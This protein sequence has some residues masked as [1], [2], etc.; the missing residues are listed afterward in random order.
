MS[1][2]RK[3]LK[4]KIASLSALGAGALIAGAG[5]AD[6]STIYSGP[7]NVDVG[8]SGQPFYTLSLSGSKTFLSFTYFARTTTIA[9]T[10]RLHYRSISGFGPAAAGVQIATMGTARR[11]LRLFLAGAVFT[12]VAHS[13]AS[14]GGRVW[15]QSVDG[16]H[17]S[18]KIFGV[19]P[20]SHEYSLFRFTTPAGQTD[21][22]WVQLSYA[23]GVN[24]G[25]G[26]DLTII[27]YA[28]DNSGALL[29][30]GDTGAPEPSS[31]AMTGLGALALGAVGLR[32]WR[33][34]RS[35]A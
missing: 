25:T 33:K 29:P 30:A 7:V 20:F 2:H 27:D 28:W 34:N 5:R 10:D 8:A 32:R 35:A 21:Y 11:D 14:A 22:G 9:R 26:P 16:G 17:R 12:G 15:R 4:S 31:M 13:S 24:P 6:A 18:S 19:A 3:D 23:V 1:R